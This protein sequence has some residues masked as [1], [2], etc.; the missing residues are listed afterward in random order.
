MTTHHK[1]LIIGCGNR[2]RCD[3][4]LGIYAADL[5]RNQVENAS[6]ITYQQLDISLAETIVN[7][8]LVIFVDAGMIDEPFCIKRIN[9]NSARPNAA[10]TNV[11]S[12]S[13]ILNIAEKLYH[14]APL[15]YAVIIKGYDFSF[16]ERL[17]EKGRAACK[18]AVSAVIELLLLC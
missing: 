11:T 12:I 10:Y 13:E 7:Y 18:D 16:G 15:C 8:D 9:A 4:G 3:D 14:K 6:L 5:L 17:T 1:T 2:T